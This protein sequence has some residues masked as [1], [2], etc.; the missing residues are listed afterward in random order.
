MLL[1][2]IEA[3]TEVY[4]HPSTT[5][6]FPQ[7]QLGRSPRWASTRSRKQHI[8]VYLFILDQARPDLVGYSRLGPFGPLFLGAGSLGVDFVADFTGQ[9]RTTLKL[10]R[11]A[12]KG[13]PN[14]PQVCHH[15]HL[16]RI[17]ELPQT[18]G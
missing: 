2:G 3:G 9:R 11:A 14:W 17:E 15:G 6:P 7:A 16:P 10:V 8:I 18:E 4:R 1:Q 13:R 12:T 5:R